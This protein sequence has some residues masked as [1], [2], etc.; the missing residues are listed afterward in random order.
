MG[1]LGDDARDERNSQVVQLMC[2]TVARDGAYG[3]VAADDLSITGSCWV[4]LVGSHHI[5]GEEVAQVGEAADKLAG[6]VLG[7]VQGAFAL[8]GKAESRLDLSYELVIE[9]FDIDSCVVGDGAIAD[10]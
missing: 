2:Y 7:F 6:D 5:G 1:N 4:A 9:T 10:A 8:V 3:R